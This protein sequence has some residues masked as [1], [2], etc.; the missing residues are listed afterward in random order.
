[1]AQRPTHEK[2]FNLERLTQF[3]LVDGD[4]C[5][6]KTDMW[7]N[8][9]LIFIKISKEKQVTTFGDTMGADT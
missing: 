1:M 2:N 4:R 9:Q 5:L 3:G 7:E 8:V 6:G